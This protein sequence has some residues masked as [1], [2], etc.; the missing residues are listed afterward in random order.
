MRKVACLRVHRR[1]NSSGRPSRV[2]AAHVGKVI[3]SCGGLVVDEE[4]QTPPPSP[5][6][7]RSEVNNVV[8]QAACEKAGPRDIGRP[9]VGLL[10][11]ES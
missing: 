6:M 4:R 2:R 5:V 3:D 1:F 7:S 11:L 9:I 10:T 8:V